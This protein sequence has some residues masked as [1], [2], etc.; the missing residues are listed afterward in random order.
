VGGAQPLR[1][2][3]P[4]AGPGGPRARAELTSASAH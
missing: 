3:R 1:A 4:V 2:T